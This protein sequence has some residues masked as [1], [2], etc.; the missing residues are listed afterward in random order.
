VFPQV[1]DAQSLKLAPHLKDNFDGFPGNVSNEGSTTGDRNDQAV[2][3]QSQKSLTHGAAAA[4]QC[5][6]N[7]FLYHS[8]PRFQVAPIDGIPNVSFNSIR[9]SQM[10]SG[11]LWRHGNPIL[12]IF[13]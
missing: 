8:L 7:N 11:A 2:A 9:R 5:S 3:L 13:G 1:P 12:A 10:T 4:L 6:G